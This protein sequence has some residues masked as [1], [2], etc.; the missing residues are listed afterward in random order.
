[1]PAATGGNRMWLSNEIHRPTRRYVSLNIV[2]STANVAINGG[3]VLMARGAWQPPVL[4]PNSGNV[5]P[6]ILVSPWEMKTPSAWKSERLT[7]IRAH[8]DPHV[9]GATLKAYRL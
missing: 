7:L 5:E 2:R 9:S 4:A 6:P 3:S 1:V 8:P